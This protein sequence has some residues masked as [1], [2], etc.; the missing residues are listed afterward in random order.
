MG[1]KKQPKDKR[2]EGEGAPPPSSYSL[3][4]FIKPTER[5]NR[6]PGPGP[7]S[8]NLSNQDQFPTLGSSNT[9]TSIAPNSC[10]SASSRPGPVTTPT[11]SITNNACPAVPPSVPTS[12]PTSAPATSSPSYT[13]GKTKKGGLPIRVESRNK[14]KKVAVVFN[15]TGNLK[16]LL[17]ELKHAAGS[18]GVVREDTVEIQGDKTEFVE[19]FLKNKM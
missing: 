15:V 14:G 13:I 3:A 7:V 6:G 1:P 2:L 9:T 18:G 19:K 12:A 17:T 16:E 5:Q 11:S 4:D 8:G 10:W